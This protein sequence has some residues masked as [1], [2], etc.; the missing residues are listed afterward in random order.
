MS[1]KDDKNFH[2]IYEKVTEQ[3]KMQSSFFFLYRVLRT[4]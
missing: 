1:G 4:I 2:L 3:L